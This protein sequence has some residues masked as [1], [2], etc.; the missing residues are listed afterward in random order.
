MCWASAGTQCPLWTTSWAERVQGHSDPCELPHGQSECRD[1]VSLVNYLMDWA[2]A[3]TQCPLWTTSWAERVQGY[4]VPCELPHGLSECRGTVS[5][6]NYLM[7]WASAGTQCPLWTTSWA[8]RVQG[9]SV[10]CPLSDN[11]HLMNVSI[12]CE[13]IGFLVTWR[14]V[15][16]CG[17]RIL[18]LSR[19]NVHHRQRNWLDQ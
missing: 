4:S 1:T 11:L 18:S 6:L 14:D 17:R 2:S 8:E 13:H 3:G 5:L 9:H 10:P 19:V 7:C 16:V 12:T 15:S